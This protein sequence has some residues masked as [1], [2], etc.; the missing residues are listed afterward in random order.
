[1]SKT[2]PYSYALRPT[3][4]RGVK[5]GFQFQQAGVKGRA[6]ATVK[7]ESATESHKSESTHK[8]KE[9]ASERSLNGEEKSSAQASEVTALSGSNSEDQDY[10]LWGKF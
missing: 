1:M 5:L 2:G 6:T 4:H 10:P 9:S 8:S 7:T 3:H